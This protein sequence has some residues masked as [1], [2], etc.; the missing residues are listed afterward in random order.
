MNS[1]TDIMLSSGE[2]FIDPDRPVLVDDRHD[3]PHLLVAFGGIKGALGMPVFEF[4]QLTRQL[5]VQKIYFRDPE[6]AWYQKGLPGIGADFASI[7]HY[8]DNYISNNGIKKTVYVGNSMGGWAAL[9]AGLLSAGNNSVLAFSPQT[10][11]GKWQ[12]LLYGDRRWE[13]QIAKA[14]KSC[15]NGFSDIK[16][17]FPLSPFHPMINLYYS[18]LFRLDKIHARRLARFP[19][20]RLHGYR[21]DDHRLVRYLKNSQELVQIVFREFE[22]DGS[23]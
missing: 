19:N 22:R 12:R 16:K 17:L 15:G 3:S 20:V 6:Q 2:E 23:N 1:D 11:I 18:E 10:F 21:N 7:V 5:K 9:G 4:F 13:E 8:I 14:R